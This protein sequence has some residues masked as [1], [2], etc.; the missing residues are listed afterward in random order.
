MAGSYWDKIT[1][2]RVSRRRVL[3]GA[4]AAGVAAGAALV[5]GCGGGGTTSTTTPKAGTPKPGAT[6]AGDAHVLNGGGTPK[7]GGTY[8]I[9]TSVDFDTFDPHQSI[10]GGVGYFPRLYNAVI[11]RSTRDTTFRFDD[12]ASKLERVVRLRQ[13]ERA[14]VLLEGPAQFD[15]LFA[16][17]RARCLGLRAP[18][19]PTAS[20]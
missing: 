8:N 20:S 5:V 12:L 14:A 18:M 15:L 6:P 17:P 11:N 19:P 13:V 7:G 2:Q 3:Q 16:R 10:A 4:G 9:G 1:A